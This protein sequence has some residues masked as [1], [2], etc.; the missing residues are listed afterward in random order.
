MAR[1]APVEPLIDT[2]TLK[3]GDIVFIQSQTQQAAA[4][5]EATES[6]WTH[7]G[8]LIKNKSG[9]QIAEAIGP[10]KTTPLKDFIGRSKNG[11]F[12]VYRF[13]FFDP[14]TMR[15]SLMANLPKYNKPYDI[16][17]EWSEDMIYCSE[18]TYK[19]FLDVTGH[20]MGRI[21][22]MKDM[23][24]DGPYVKALIKKR[25][26]DTGRELDPEEP[27]LTPVSQMV[28]PNMVLV[29]KSR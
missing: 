2:T 19:V 27:I 9:W 17:F 8:I 18:L 22:K 28:D 10:L 23:R 6:L 13:K 3:E 16:Y 20:E 21:Q 26:T 5:R 4:L 7:V 14:T 25:L 11:A 1:G 12:E 29:Q 24:L 15:D